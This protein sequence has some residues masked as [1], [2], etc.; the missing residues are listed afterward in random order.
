MVG[1]EAEA[2]WGKAEGMEF[3]QPPEEMAS[4]GPNGTLSSYG[5]VI[6]LR[7]SNHPITDG[8]GARLCSDAWL[9]DKRQWMFGY[10]EK[11]FPHEGSQAVEQAV[12][13]GLCCL[14]W[15][16]SHQPDKAL[17]NKVSVHDWLL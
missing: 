14:P 11:P 8:Y 4:W 5:T 7:L 1:A 12:Q 9:E 6:E 15:A 3:V 16:L 10:T 17:S 13:K 2:L